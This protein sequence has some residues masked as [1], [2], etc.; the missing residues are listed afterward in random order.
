MVEKIKT[1]RDIKG[2]LQYV[3][4]DVLWVLEKKKNHIVI[5]IIECLTKNFGTSLQE[6][7][8]EWFKNWLEFREGDFVEEDNFFFAMN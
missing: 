7:L 3:N 5:K 8:D 1:N 4:D 2:L 6:K